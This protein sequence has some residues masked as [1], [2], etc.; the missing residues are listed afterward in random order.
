MTIYKQEKFYVYYL[1]DPRNNKIFYIGE[2]CDNRAYSHQ[3]FKS[4]CN[5]PHKDRVIKKIHDAGLEVIVKLVRENLTKD[6][7][8]AFERLLIE[9][10]GLDNLTNIVKDSSPPVLCGPSNGF[11]G[12]TH[13]EE[14]KVLMGNVNRGRDIKTEKGKT[15][16][17]QHMKKRMLG[18]NNPKYDH[19]IYTFKHKNGLIENLTKCEF[20]KKYDLPR[21]NVQEILVKRSRSYKGWMVVN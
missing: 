1:I 14:N 19:T 2:G 10:H 16:I 9:Q 6:Q 8:R 13:T 12:K 17:S 7:A 21:S 5:N 3:K 20:Y 11:Y 4:R 18:V 15:S